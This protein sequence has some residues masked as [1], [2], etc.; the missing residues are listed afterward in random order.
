MHTARIWITS[1]IPGGA[2]GYYDDKEFGNFI[3]HTALKFPKGCAGYTCRTPN[4]K[5][6]AYHPFYFGD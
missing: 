3:T 5:G 6:K 4:V 1:A 2:P